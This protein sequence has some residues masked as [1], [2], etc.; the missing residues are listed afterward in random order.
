MSTKTKYGTLEEMNKINK[1]D[2]Q[3][4]GG[5]GRQQRE[6]VISWVHKVIREVTA[7]LTGY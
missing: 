7:L 5:V 4:V 3:G 1:P 2:P 6:G